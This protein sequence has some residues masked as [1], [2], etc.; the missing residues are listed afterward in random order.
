VRVIVTGAAGRIG[1]TVTAG[2][3]ERGHDVTGID[4]VPAEGVD[5]VD[6]TE[7][8]ALIHC[9]TGCDAV[10]HLAGYAG[11]GS[12]ATAMRTHA[13]MTYAVLEAMRITGVKRLVYASSHHAVGFTPAGV[14]VDVDVRP[15]PNTFYGVAKVAAEALC[16]LYVDRFGIAAACLRIGAFRDRPTS[17]R[18][19]ASWLSPD[20]A[21]RLVEACLTT[22]DLGY[23]VIYGI[24]A[25]TR[26]FL[27]LEP[28]RRLGYHP[29]DDAETYADQILA[30]PETDEDAFEARHVGGR[31][32]AV[33]SYLQ[34]RR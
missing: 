1:R 11:E 6:A 2:L 15:R 10:V 25:N 3:T 34:E 14:E 31:F 22:P 4:L 18:Q 20:D 24:S 9:L 7:I 28:G 5:R 23:E 21:V 13:D 12:Y 27:D 17:R 16:S 30:V 29:R 32:C 33:P 8:P 19:L 26:A